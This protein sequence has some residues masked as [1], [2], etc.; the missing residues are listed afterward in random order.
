MVMEY[1]ECSVQLLFILAALLVS[2]FRYINSKKRGWGYSVGFFACSL[3]S[4]Y[5]WTFYLLIMGDNPNASSFITYLGW[6]SAFAMLFLLNLHLKDKDERRYFHPLMLLPIPL[7]AYQ[8]KLY[9]Q[10]DGKLLSAYQVTVCTAVA[11]IGIQSI[12]WYLKNRKS[13]IKPPYVA[14]ISLLNITAEFG[15]WT[16]TCFEGWLH[17]LYYPCSLFSSLTYLLLLR[18]I[19]RRY[20]GEANEAS[21]VN[22]D[23]RIQNIMKGSYAFIVAVCALGGFFLCRWIRDLLTEDVQMST[24]ADVYAIISAVLFLISLIL[25]AFAMAIVLIVYFEQKI[26]E[27]NRLREEKKVAE[28]SNAA[29]SD[30]LANMSHEIRTPINAVLG[31]N[32][33]IMQESLKARDMLP[34]ERA[35]IRGV[36]A[37]ITEHSGNIDC[38]GNNLL[39]IIN[40]ILDFSK[41][42]AGK[43]DLNEREYMLSSVLND[44]SNTVLFK[45]KEKGLTFNTET[46]R[47]LPDRLFGD[48]VR[49]RQIMTNFLNNAVKYTDRGSV[50]LSVSGNGGAYEKDGTAELTVSVKDTGIGIRAEELDR[51][52]DKFERTD[53]K[54]NSTVEGT[55]LGLAI[56][57]RLADMMGG[58]ISVESE[59][60]KGSVFT[61]TIPQRVV[62]AEPIGDFR[63]KFERSFEELNAGDVSYRAPEAKILIV[64]DTRMNLLVAA[65]LLRSTEIKTETAESGAEALN[66]A[67][68]VRY[69]LILMD[70]R[71]PVMD[72]VETLHRLR[73]QENGLN[74]AT[75]V[76]CLTADA[77]S[78]A[79]ERY[80]AEGFDDYLSKPIDSEEMK[81]TIMKYLPKEKM[82]VGQDGS[83]SAAAGEVPAEELYSRLSRA[84]IDTDKGL[85]YCQYDDELYRTMLL[86]FEQGFEERLRTM[87]EY[88]DSRDARNYGILVHSLKS[89]SR[90]IGAEE[91]AELSASLERAADGGRWDMITA[92]HAAMTERYRSVAEEI[93]AAIGSGSDELPAN[94]VSSDDGEIIEFFPD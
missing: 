25:V 10:F 92:S 27:N 60:G 70:Q 53:M 66:K 39:A 11:C 94:V 4:S 16:S 86:E 91:L 14:V 37:E 30:F 46:D 43:L 50:T 62:S 48:D 49:I 79:K 29:K 88:Y 28:Q 18:A 64:D 77:L 54:R 7:N 80:V 73:E 38:A 76:I 15:M 78:G 5:F 36:F 68:E 31:M 12:M 23:R 26:T 65:G 1:V 3:L 90:T 93:S 40:D 33:M 6:N 57:H 85:G 56:T 2:L 74:R 8:L 20:R 69:D 83:E 35:A 13:G 47:S 41:I 61:V 82:I 63:T 19:R 9:F 34:K 89:S 52:F 81:R 44:V 22:I 67:A 71:M 24:E 87:Q 17:D 58:R 72:G 42:E 59:Y 75:P 51:I 21:G 55:G 84:G 32:K 45:A